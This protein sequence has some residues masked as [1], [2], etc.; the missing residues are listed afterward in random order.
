SAKD[1][2]LLG[3]APHLVVDGALATAEALGAPTV[4]LCV[5]G[6]DGRS[7]E[8]ASFDA[9]ARSLEAAVAER[10]TRGVKFALYRPPHRYVSGE[11][12]ALARWLHGG[13]ALPETRRLPLAARGVDGRP[14]ALANAETFAHVGLLARHGPAWFRGAGTDEDPGTTLVTVSGA[15][16]RSV[17]TEVAFGASVADVLRAAGGCTDELR[18]VLVGGYGGTWVTAE[19]AAASRIGARRR[20]GTL[21]LGPGIVCVLPASACGL[22]ETAR[23]VR[24]MAAE[25]AGQCGPCVH[26]LPALAGALDRLVEPASRADAELAWGQLGRWCGQIA[27]RGACNHPDGVVRLVRSALDVFADDVAVHHTGVQCGRVRRPPVLA[28]PEVH[29]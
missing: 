7:P 25:S 8:R 16:S 11:S 21:A 12:S 19:E 17:V 14:T 1:R 5:A 4:A 26:G 2:L 23:V 9:A 28:V 10:D 20:P 6:P 22:H 24:F 15:V 18:A 13:P 27:G 3:L 29:R